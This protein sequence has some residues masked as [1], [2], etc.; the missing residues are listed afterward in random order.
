VASRV[1][2]AFTNMISRR[3]QREIY[4]FGFSGNGKMELGVY[5][6][7]ATLPASLIIIDCNWNMGPP[8]ITANVRQYS[9][10]RPDMTAL[11]RNHHIHGQ[12][13]S[14]PAS[15]R[16]AVLDIYIIYYYII[17]YGC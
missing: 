6:H 1:G 2:N 16:P 15:Q 4:N 5:Q 13:A 12:P 9:S 8:S 7:L 11:D 14:Q 3:L 10:P 17:L